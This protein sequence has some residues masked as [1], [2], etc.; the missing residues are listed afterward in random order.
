MAILDRAWGKPAQ[1][2]DHSGRVGHD[3]SDLSDA[4]LAAI[5]T[6]ETSGG[7]RLN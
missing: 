1:A 6:G 7:R 2:I 4:D 5:I 3:L